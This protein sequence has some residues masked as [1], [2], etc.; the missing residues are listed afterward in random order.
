MI[1]LLYGQP[2]C[3]KTTLAKGIKEKY[4]INIPIVTIDGDEWRDICSKTIISFDI[5]IKNLAYCI[6]VIDPAQKTSILKWNIVN[7]SLD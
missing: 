6:F 3:G 7:L 2:A 5:G 1:V 4:N